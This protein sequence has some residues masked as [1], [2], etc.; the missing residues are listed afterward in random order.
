F[1]RLPAR[2]AALGY[3]PACR[4]LSIPPMAYL[5]RFDER[6][7][8]KFSRREILTVFLIAG[9]TA[10]FLGAIFAAQFTIFTAPQPTANDLAVGKASPLTI[11]APAQITFASD[12]E[13]NLARDQA[14]HAVQ[15]IYDAPDANI[16]R[17]QIRRAARIIDFL[18]T[19]RADAYASD[20]DKVDWV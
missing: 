20:T 13:T 14:A 19:V 8:V 9:V 16:A 4:F 17:D 7:Q 10:L 6:D 1:V 3:M 2:R 11:L 15:D 18:D 12:L 5:D